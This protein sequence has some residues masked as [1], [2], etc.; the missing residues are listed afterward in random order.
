[1][2]IFLQQAAQYMGVRKGD[3]LSKTDEK[4]LRAKAKKMKTSFKKQLRKQD[5]GLDQ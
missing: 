5:K 2:N 1:M 3:R 4:R